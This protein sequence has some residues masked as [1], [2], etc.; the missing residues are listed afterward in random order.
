MLKLSSPLK[1]KLS[2]SFH[3]DTSL[4]SFFLST[5]S[6]V[7]PESKKHRKFISYNTVKK[8]TEKG[9]SFYKGEHVINSR[10]YLGEYNIYQMI[11]RGEDK[12]LNKKRCLSEQQ[13]KRKRVINNDN[14]HLV[15]KKVNSSVSPFKKIKNKINLKKKNEMKLKKEEEESII[16]FTIKQIEVIKNPDSQ[17]YPLYKLSKQYRKEK[18]E[19][20]DKPFK[21]KVKILSKEI[22]QKEKGIQKELLRLKMVRIVNDNLLS[23]KFLSSD[24]TF[25]DRKIKCE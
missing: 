21:E 7:S 12:S 1:L 2:K 18:Q 15:L 16:P 23:R 6:N 9:Y 8:K 3:L 11:T 13:S 4:N 24:K 20:Y 14:K 5:H 17:L 22:N 10:I 19:Y 25:F